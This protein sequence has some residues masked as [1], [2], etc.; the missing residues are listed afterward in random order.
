MVQHTLLCILWF[1]YREGI[2]SELHFPNKPGRS[3][4]KR[5]HGLFTKTTDFIN[6]LSY[7]IPHTACFRLAQFSTRLES[8]SHKTIF[9][10]QNDLFFSD[11]VAQLLWLKS[12]GHEKL[13]LGKPPC[14]TKCSRMEALPSAQ[15]A[16]P[17]GKAAQLVSEVK[18]EQISTVPRCIFPITEQL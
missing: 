12:S 8:C 1:P 3:L 10:K 6:T 4:R 9:F 2:W 11:K 5:W 15:P 13:R 18:A 7:R 14:C 16:I 17:S